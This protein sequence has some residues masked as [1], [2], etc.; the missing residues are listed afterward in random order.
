MEEDDR[1]NEQESEDEADYGE[2]CPEEHEN[3]DEIEEEELNG[4][5]SPQDDV[6]VVAM[7]GVGV[8]HAPPPVFSPTFSGYNCFIVMYGTYMQHPRLNLYDTGVCCF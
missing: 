7:G 2:E 1:K 3:K 6:R 8:T 4:D 5:N